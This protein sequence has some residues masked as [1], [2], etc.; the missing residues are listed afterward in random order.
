MTPL[1]PFSVKLTP[2]TRSA[3]KAAA[4]DVG[5]SE[6][7][8]IVESVES[9][10]KMITEEGGEVLP[11]VVVL[12]RAARD[13]RTRPHPLRTRPAPSPASTCRDKAGKAPQRGM[14]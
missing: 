5:Y 1:K 2:E 12:V 8:F 9:V 14:G 6:N 4:G 11:R 10:L 7:Q 13:H 3:I